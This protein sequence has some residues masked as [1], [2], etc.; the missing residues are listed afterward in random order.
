MSQETH[1]SNNIDSIH[2]QD[3]SN[4]Q[5]LIKTDRQ[6]SARFSTEKKNQHNQSTTKK[7]SGKFFQESVNS[8]PKNYF[9]DGHSD[10]NENEQFSEL[11]SQDSDYVADIDLGSCQIHK[12]NNECVCLIDM[13][14]ICTKCALFGFHKG[15]DIISED[16]FKEELT[17]NRKK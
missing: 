9:E 17:K 14:A 8:N 13:I 1:T 11:N 5:Q 16:A 6:Q 4:N 12:R 7:L 3:D 2:L 10:D 15:H